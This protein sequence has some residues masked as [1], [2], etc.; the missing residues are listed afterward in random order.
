MSGMFF[1]CSSLSKLNLSN[2]NAQ[3]VEFM[4]LMFGQCSS[5]SNINLANFI[6]QN[7]TSMHRLFE[8]CSSLKKSNIITKDKKILEKFED[9]YLY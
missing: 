7:A 3:N 9:Y 2:F 6:T 4:D 5:L 8:G 1:N